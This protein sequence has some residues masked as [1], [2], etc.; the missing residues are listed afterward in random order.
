MC[1][2]CKYTCTFQY[3]YY[4]YYYYYYYYTVKEW[5]MLETHLCFNDHKSSLSSAKLKFKSLTGEE[6][7]IPCKVRRWRHLLVANLQ[8]CQVS[9][10]CITWITQHGGN[11]SWQYFYNLYLSGCLQLKSSSVHFRV[12]RQHIFK[13]EWI[14]CQTMFT[15]GESWPVSQATEREWQPQECFIQHMAGNPWR[16][17]LIYNQNCTAVRTATWNTAR[18]MKKKTSMYI[19][20]LLSARMN[21]HGNNVKCLWNTRLS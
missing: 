8:I 14:I 5:L 15:I 7:W 2:K 20:Q 21:K 13:C 19:N 17:I 12:A 16:G 1:N 18:A 10:V 3:S 11:S 9:S 6:N 4:Y